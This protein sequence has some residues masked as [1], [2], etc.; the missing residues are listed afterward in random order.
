[1]PKLSDFNP[2]DVQVVDGGGQTQPKPIPK[3]SDFS[4]DQVQIIAEPQAVPSDDS[5]GEKAAQITLNAIIAVGRGWDSI[6]GAPT[7][8]A[9]RAAQKGESPLEAF[10]RQFARAPEKAATGKEIAE[11]AGLS[12][13]KFKTPFKGIDGRPLETSPAAVGGAAVDLLADWT[14]VVPVSKVAKGVSVGAK[15]GGAA[16]SKMAGKASSLV[17][18]KEATEAVKNMA[19]QA[20]SHVPAEKIAA[21]SKLT[22]DEIKAIPGV[23][24]IK[25]K[26]D[27]IVSQQNK[28]KEVARESVKRSEQE[29]ADLYREQVSRLKSQTVPLA[30]A[31]EILATLE[32]EK[33]ILGSLSEQADDALS[34]VPGTIDKRHIIGFLGKIAKS[35]GAGKGGAV[36]GDEAYNAMARIAAYRD[37]AVAQL[38]DQ[39]DFVTLRDI[40][41]QVR[42]DINFDVGAGEF[43]DSLNKMRLEFTHGMSEVLKGRAKG[44]GAT[45]HPAQLEYEQYMARM[46]PLAESLGNLN[47]HFGNRERALSSLQLV[48]N[49][50][51]KAKV[52]RDMLENHA[53]LT[54]N[55]GILDQ[56]DSYDK[57]RTLLKRAQSEDLTGEFFPDRVKML[58]AQ[59]AMLDEAERITEPLN[60][61]GQGRT[62]DIIKNMQGGNQS[63]E[64][65]RALKL[66]GKLAGNDFLEVIDKRGI[67]DA[68]AKDATRGSRLTN[69][70]AI[71]GGAAGSIVAGPTGAAVGAGAGASLGALADKN[72]GPLTR[73]YLDRLKEPIIAVP[74][75]A[76]TIDLKAIYKSRSRIDN[77]LKG[78]QFIHTQGDDHE[79]KREAIKRRIKA[80]ENP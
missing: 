11:A 48:A 9:V 62:Q 39:I 68:F 69:W 80:G 14:N 35:G 28:A 67:I 3:L 51:G 56:L 38:P 73:M 63:I 55:K 50:K 27:L 47:R 5:F 40:L 45:A 77:T 15:E 10:G 37:R 34:R 52:L 6:T 60:R 79:K 17:I 43:N 74:K 16:L 31:D 53:K 49:D 72:A 66:A 44:K 21:Y 23:E 42:K 32:N 22:P 12:E 75:G 61:L 58:D 8:A 18:G 70:G 36:I 26:I 57:A 1:M 20:F 30:Q 13:D 65:R 76:P 29:L 64:D 54:G 2:D 33:K 19:L 78:A 41:K 7:R 24:D 4:P 46:A 59:R 71:T 25:N